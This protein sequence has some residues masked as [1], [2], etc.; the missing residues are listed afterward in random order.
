MVERCL[1]FVC[2][3]QWIFFIKRHLP[4][5]SMKM[6]RML[7]TVANVSSPLMIGINFLNEDVVGS[8]AGFFGGL[9][10]FA[11]Y[12]LMQIVGIVFDGP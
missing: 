12:K 8:A 2:L 3:H 7:R 5:V 1:C 4:E 9:L 11:G 6:M 10:A